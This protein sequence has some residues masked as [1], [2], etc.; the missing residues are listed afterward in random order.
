VVE[1][2]D[3]F[4]YV[5]DGVLIEFIDDISHFLGLFIRENTSDRHQ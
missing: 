3:Q 2:I 1:A 5:F 4:V